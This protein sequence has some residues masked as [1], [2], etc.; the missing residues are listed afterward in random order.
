MEKSLTSRSALDISTRGFTIYSYMR[1]A[2]QRRGEAGG[3]VGR[4]MF[5]C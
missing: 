1:W 4:D 5:P 3:E 2:R